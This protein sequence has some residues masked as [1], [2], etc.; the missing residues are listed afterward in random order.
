MTRK[1]LVEPINTK[2]DM[3]FLDFK[4]KH[5]KVVH[6]RGK[7]YRIEGRDE[8]F[9]SLSDANNFVRMLEDTEL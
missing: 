2:L 6:S 8:R 1:S 7:K 9:D 4:P 5:Y 3:S